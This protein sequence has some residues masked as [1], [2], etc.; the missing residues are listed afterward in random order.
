M[1]TAFRTCRTSRAARA[2]RASWSRP[3]IV[4]G[5]LLALAAAGPPE[6]RPGPEAGPRFD[7]APDGL[8]FSKAV[9]WRGVL[10]LSGEIGVDP[11]TG[12]LAGPDI[13]AQARQ[14][15]E[16]IR[17]T[18]DRHGLTMGDIFKCTVMLADMA[19]WPAFNE[20]YVT[21]FRPGRLP[22]RS[23]FGASGLAL[24]GRLEIECRA[25]LTGSQAARE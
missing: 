13:R 20:V 22:A 23:A 7:P 4:L 11:A 5:A 17:T 25:A 2:L 24:G 14:A 9:A 21:Y 18:L 8:P 12:R 1:T 19:D 15:M 16:N 10:Y 3:A 6:G